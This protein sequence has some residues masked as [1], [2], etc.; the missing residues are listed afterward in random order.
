MIRRLLLYA[1]LTASVTAPAFGQQVNLTGAG[2]TFANPLYTAWASEYAKLHPGVQ[3]NYQS[4]GSGGGIG[5]LSDGIV[6]FGGTDAPMTD[7]Q[8][9]TAKTKLT[10][11]WMDAKLGT[12]STGRNWRTVLKLQELLGAGTGA[13]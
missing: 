8:L 6:D 9:A 1:A 5:R 11:A 3:I 10:N 2:S 13:P 4:I 12:V 7:A